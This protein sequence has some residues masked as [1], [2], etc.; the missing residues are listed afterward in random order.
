MAYGTRIRFLILFLPGLWL[1][2][3]GS[4]G[5][6]SSQTEIDSGILRATGIIKAREILDLKTIDANTSS[7]VAGVEGK[8]F[9]LEYLSS[10]TGYKSNTAIRYD[11]ELL[12]GNLL[13]VYSETWRYRV[14]DCVNLIINLEDKKTQ[15]VIFLNK[16]DC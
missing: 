10:G 9:G 8:S 1:V 3:C 16:N 13:T 11:I 6:S 15:P 14:D 12:D 5:S 7:E 2:G 4:T